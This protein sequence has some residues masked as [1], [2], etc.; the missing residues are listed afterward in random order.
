MIVHFADIRRG[1][2][3][4]ATLFLGINWYVIFKFPGFVMVFFDQY[5][6][7]KRNLVGMT[8]ND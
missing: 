2:W 8:Q 6:V 5:V 4:Q 1:L 7:G 3:E